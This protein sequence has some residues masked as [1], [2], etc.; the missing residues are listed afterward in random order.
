MGGI[1]G[2]LSDLLFG[3]PEIPEMDYE[4]LAKLL[5]LG[6]DENRY[7]QQGLFTSNMWDAGKDTLTT[8]VNER[9]QPGFDEATRML[10]EGLTPNPREGQYN[11]LADA[12]LARAMANYGRPGS[13]PIERR[14]RQPARSRD[15]YMNKRYE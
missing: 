13:R 3:K 4:E 15:D 11:A 2:G 7:S 6:I 14:E 5:K 12:H 8:S 1:L 9:F 10:N